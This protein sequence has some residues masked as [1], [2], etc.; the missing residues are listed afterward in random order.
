MDYENSDDSEDEDKR[1]SNLQMSRNDEEPVA[2]IDMRKAGAQAVSASADTVEKIST[3]ST[4]GLRGKVVLCLAE[5]R[6]V[7]SR[8]HSK[9]LF[10]Y[11]PSCLLKL[12]LAIETKGQ[13]ENPTALQ[14]K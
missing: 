12:L 14:L 1:L 9:G 2:E 11:N 4:E 3:S 10:P 13:L 6:I 7:I 5:L 8:L